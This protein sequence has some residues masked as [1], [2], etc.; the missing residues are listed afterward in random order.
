MKLYLSYPMTGEPDYGIPV[1]KQV[2]ARLREQGYEIV[3]P[4]EIMHG[5]TKHLNPA[6][7]HDDYVREDIRL[8]LSQCE[9]I[10][11]CSRWTYSAGCREELRWAVAHGLRI[12]YAEVFITRAVVVSVVPMD[13]GEYV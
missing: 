7:G 2:A 12:F 9:G 6:Y 1:A 11:L 3:A 13:G 10:V 8:G 5:G 4:H